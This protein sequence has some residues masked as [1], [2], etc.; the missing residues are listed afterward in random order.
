MA[1]Q[2]T[3]DRARSFTDAWTRQDMETTASYLA[4][5]VVFHGPNGDLA[6]KEGYLAGL[7][8]FARAVQSATILAAS[9]DADRAII[10]Y[11]LVTPGG[12]VS[13]AEMLTF[14]D[15]KIVDDRFVTSPRG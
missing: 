5:D 14:R 10:L 11:D 15:G 1:Q 6:G 13:C 3:A 12:T 7:T 4:D 2:S 8:N 9:G